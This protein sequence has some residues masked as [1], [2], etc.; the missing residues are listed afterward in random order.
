MSNRDQV[1]MS[2]TETADF[3]AD[4]LKVQVASIGHLVLG[5]EAVG[6]RHS[7]PL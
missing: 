3:L 5:D 7:R 1:T 6:D 2:E 4:N